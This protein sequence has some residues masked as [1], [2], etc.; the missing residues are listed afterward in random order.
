MGQSKE[1]IK[2]RKR[3]TPSGMESLYLDIYLNGQ[4][5]YEYLKLY[6]VPETNRQDRQKNLETLKLAEAIRAKRLVELRN[7]EYGFKSDTMGNWGNWRSALKHL[8]KY[9]PRLKHL[10]WKD[11]DRDFITGFKEYLENEACAWSE[12]SRE[13]TKDRPLARNSRVS[14]FNKL[15]A[16]CNKAYDGRI[17]AYN[18]IRGIEGI[19]A[20]E[21]KRMY[22]TI[23]EVRLLAKTECH[24][25]SVKRAF[26]FSCL[27]GLRRSD[28]ERLKWRDV[29]QQ[30]EFTRI[31][32]NQKK[33]NG[34]EYLDLAPEAVEFIGVVK[35]QTS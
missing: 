8:L 28:I 2:L 5:S 23:E 19:K 34:L 31:I 18:P 27:T 30:G 24:Y 33:T 17:I 13:R 20:E 4:R 25:P 32:F 12:D 3:K 1:P 22:L 10:Q 7:S 21:G 35:A 6:L 11:I 9:E 14:Y 15:R 16:C 29:F 26:L